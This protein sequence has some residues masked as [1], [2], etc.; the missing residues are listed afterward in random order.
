MINW[1]PA[2]LTALSDEE[3]IYKE[4]SSKLYHVRYQIVGSDEFITIATTRPETI[5]GDTAVCV[6]PKDERYKHLHGRK[7]IVP[8]INREV[9][10]IADEYVEMEFG[11]GC[12]K[13]TPA[14]DMN[15]FMLGEKYKLEII[16]MMNDNGTIS[17]AGCPISQPAAVAPRRISAAITSSTG[18]ATTPAAV[19]RQG[20]LNSPISNTT[21]E[22]KRYESKLDV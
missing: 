20:T 7:A 18:T 22:D 3:V 21:A 13:V 9:P 4:V 8:L 1:D 5:L 10:I 2:A 6:N 11:T 15:D 16:N 12:L 17:E 14:H 19:R